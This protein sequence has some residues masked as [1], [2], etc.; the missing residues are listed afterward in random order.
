[1]QI[2]HIDTRADIHRLGD[3]VVHGFKPDW[4]DEWDGMAGVLEMIE[5]SE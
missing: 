3:F 4:L 2:Q 5:D 1:V